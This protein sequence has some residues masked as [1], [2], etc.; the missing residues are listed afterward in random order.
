MFVPFLFPLCF[1]DFLA[2]DLANKPYPDLQSYATHFKL[3]Y[4][5][6]TAAD[7][8]KCLIEIQKCLAAARSHQDQQDQLRERFLRKQNDQVIYIH[9]CFLT[10]LAT[11][12]VGLFGWT[13]H[14]H[15]KLEFSTHTNNQLQISYLWLACF[16]L[17]CH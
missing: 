17:A 12:C 11:M 16:L 6:K 1:P 3:P 10:F 8:S 5:T 13:F 7:Y 14:L 2:A 15:A 9:R 4:R